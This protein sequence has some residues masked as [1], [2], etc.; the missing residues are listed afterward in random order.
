L[1]CNIDEE[2]VT[3]TISARNITY[4]VKW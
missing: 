2:E 4:A 1:I 3:F